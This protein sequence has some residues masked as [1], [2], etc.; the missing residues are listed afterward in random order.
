M[1]R[2]AIAAVSLAAVSLA[3]CTSVRAPDA[4]YVRAGRQ[5]LEFTGD[6][7]VDLAATSGRYTPA[8]IQQKRDKVRAFELA[9]ERAELMLGIAPAPDTEGNE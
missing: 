1:K 8:D 3:G 4:A 6:E 9:T 2:K 7:Y 5:F